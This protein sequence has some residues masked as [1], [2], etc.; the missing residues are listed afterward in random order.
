M[1]ALD[2]DA[3]FFASERTRA[4]IGAALY[5]GAGLLEALVVPKLALAIFFLL[6]NFY[7][8]TS[9]GLPLGPVIGHGL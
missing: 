8:L 7:A 5:A 9:E 3:A 6:P 2:E 1:R 4:L